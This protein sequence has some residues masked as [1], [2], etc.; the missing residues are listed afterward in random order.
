MVADKAPGGDVSHRLARVRW[1]VNMC[2]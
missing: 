1:L 2:F